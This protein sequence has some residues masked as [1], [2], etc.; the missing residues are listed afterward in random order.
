[1]KV[2]VIVL[3]AGIGTRFNSKTP[4]PLIPLNGQPLITYSLDIFQQCSFVNTVTLVIHSD[5]REEYEHVVNEYKLDKV[6]NIIPGGMTRSESVKEGLKK[7][8][9][10]TEIVVIHDGA[11]PFIT[12]DMVK[13][14]LEACQR[15]QAV[16]TATPVKPTI[17]RVNR[18]EMTVK[19]TLNRE[20]LWE[21]Q[22]PQVFARELLEKAHNEAENQNP[23]DD[24]YLVEQLGIKVKILPGDYRNIKVTTVE[25]LV[26]AQ[27]LLNLKKG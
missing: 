26:I 5:Y 12:Q 20:E 17:K 6:K 18:E 1:M 19:E 27:A 15:H 7:L 21:V 13:G 11:R 8:S 4:K 14:L 2:E 24:A 22:T 9:P 23:T 10:N 25:D 16:I 3:S